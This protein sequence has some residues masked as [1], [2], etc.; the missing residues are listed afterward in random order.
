MDT[1][2][3]SHGLT[4]SN[5]YLQADLAALDAAQTKLEEE[6][7][8]LRNEVPALECEIEELEGTEAGIEGRISELQ[9]ER[10]EIEQR[11]EQRAAG[12]VDARNNPPYWKKALR[13][14]ATVVKKVPAYQ[15]ARSY[16]VSFPAPSCEIGMEKWE[17]GELQPRCQPVP[18]REPRV[19]AVVP[20]FPS[21]IPAAGGAADDGSG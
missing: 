19:V 6:N 1:L 3:L 20:G 18:N 12:S 4:R 17:P 16:R 11:L 21:R 2:Y 8:A 7:T 15:T 5:D 13:V 10:L 14:S 9:T